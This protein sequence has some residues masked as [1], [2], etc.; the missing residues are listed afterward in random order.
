MF[1]VIKKRLMILIGVVIL[2]LGALAGITA[3]VKTTVTS[4]ADTKQF[5]VVLDAGHGGVDK[6]V[7]GVTSKVSEAEMNLK[8]TKEV[9]KLLEA[10]N[11]NVVLTRE[12]EAGL[13][14]DSL[15]NFKKRDMAERKRIINESKPNVVVSIHC[16]KFPS[17]SRRGA[18]VFFDKNSENSKEFANLIQN[19]LNTLNKRETEREYEALSG[20]YY[21]LKCSP[22]TSVIVECGFLSNP[23]DDKLLNDDK[24]RSELSY[25]IYSAINGFLLKTNG[26]FKNEVC[27]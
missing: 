9:K 1:L 18:Q 21:I 11:I 2:V 17:A 22:Y 15:D 7:V 13:Y 10:N 16:N 27:V 26:A 6:G 20:D 3:I 24:Y 8:I 19:S 4:A 5:T 12:T 25:N 14:G 23:D